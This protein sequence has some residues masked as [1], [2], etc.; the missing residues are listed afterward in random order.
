MTVHH[1]MRTF[2]RDL[3]R[4]EHFGQ[5]S[6]EPRWQ[7]DHAQNGARSLAD[8]VRMAEISGISRQRPET[9]KPKY[10]YSALTW[11]ATLALSVP[12]DC[13]VSGAESA[14]PIRIW[15]SAFALHH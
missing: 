12:L 3:I 7:P 8:L 6:C 1:R 14:G 4:G 2:Y 11:R 5:Q 13:S 15:T 9:A 10:V